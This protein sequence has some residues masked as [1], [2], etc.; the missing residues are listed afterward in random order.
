M[1]GILA[2]L[3]CMLVLAMYIRYDNA[4]YLKT[5]VVQEEAKSYLTTLVTR[6]KSVPGYKDEYP[7]TFVNTGKNRDKT[8][9][10]IEEFDD[11]N[12]AGSRRLRTT[13]KDY[14]SR[15]FIN[16]WCGF[17]PKWADARLF[18]DLPE[19]QEMTHYPDDG[20]IKVVNQTVVVKF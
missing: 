5:A 3:Y 15:S 19:V 16:T 11:L 7:V 2:F 4:C 1:I 17:S 14:A 10:K 18:H 20:S 9:T 12:L 13:V 6:I 8:I